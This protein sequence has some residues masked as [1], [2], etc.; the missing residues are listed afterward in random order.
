MENF[1]IKHYCND[2]FG[3]IEIEAYNMQI[4]GKPV[5]LLDELEEFINKKDTRIGNLFNN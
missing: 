5:E 1:E 4:V 3:F 2:E